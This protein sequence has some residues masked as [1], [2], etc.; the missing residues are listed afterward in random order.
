MISAVRATCRLWEHSVPTI[1]QAFFCAAY[2]SSPGSNSNGNEDNN[3]DNQS[4]KYVE[5]SESGSGNIDFGT[6]RTKHNWIGSILLG[7]S[8]LMN[9]CRASFQLW[10]R[11]SKCETRGEAE[12][13]PRDFQQCRTF[14]RPHERSHEW[15][16]PQDLER[17]V[18]YTSRHYLLEIFISVYASH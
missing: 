14:V 17:Q 11:I 13:S 6:W 9:R 8:P 18:R 12:S 3:L 4:D 15:G 1:R 2:C 10:Y 16:S 5:N 7:F